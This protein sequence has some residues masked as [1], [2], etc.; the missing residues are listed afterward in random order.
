[1]HIDRLCVMVEGRAS[2]LSRRNACQPSLSAA[3]ARSERRTACHCEDQ[4][5]AKSRLP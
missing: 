3:W 4:S 1:M 5:S 2:C